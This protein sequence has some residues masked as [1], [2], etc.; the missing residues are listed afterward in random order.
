M[1]LIWKV[2]NNLFIFKPDIVKTVLQN[3]EESL[4]FNR[5]L[6]QLLTAVPLFLFTVEWLILITEHRLEGGQL[7]C[8]TSRSRNASVQQMITTGAKQ[9]VEKDPYQLNVW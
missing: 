8:G 5:S 2:K 9:R 7:M 4:G 1:E 6:Q 3:N